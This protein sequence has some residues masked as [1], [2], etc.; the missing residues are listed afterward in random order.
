MINKDGINSIEL[1]NSSG[2]ML[3]AITKNKK[4][5]K[6]EPQRSAVAIVYSLTALCGLCNSLWLRGTPELKKHRE[7][8]QRATG[9]QGN[10]ARVEFN[11]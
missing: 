8:D 9:T 4:D 11:Q 2:L 6:F 5:Y 7:V 3:I 10:F 1:Q